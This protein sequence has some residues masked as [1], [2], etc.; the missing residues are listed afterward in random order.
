MINQE[1]IES[2]Y[3]VDASE[4][5]GSVE[6]AEQIENWN[7][8]NIHELNIHNGTSNAAKIWYGYVLRIV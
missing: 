4:A 8:E 2:I 6:I 3:D 7:T 5:C 1:Q